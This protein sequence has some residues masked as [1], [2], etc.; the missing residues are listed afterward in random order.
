MKSKFFN[1]LF[2]SSI[3]FFI[4]IVNTNPIIAQTDLKKSSFRRV[5]TG[6]DKKGKSVIVGDGVVPPNAQ[7]SGNYGFGSDIWVEKFVPV[8]I[9]EYADQIIDYNA[10]TE[11]PPGGVVARI[12]LWNPGN[13]YPMHI[14]K[15]IDIIFIISGQL[16]LIV[17]EGETILNPGD[18]V[19]QRGTNHGWEVI[20]DKPCIFA[21]VLLSAEKSVLE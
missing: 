14:T 9:N 17:D 12:I 2:L 19:V 15:T 8:E 3:I 21:G 1:T 16:K 5:V 11:P 20:G 4:L 10:Q 6:N 18:C 7:Y 13:K